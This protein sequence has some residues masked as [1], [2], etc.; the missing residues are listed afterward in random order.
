MVDRRILSAAL[1]WEASDIEESYEQRKYSY[2][3][4]LLC[5]LDTSKYNKIFKYEK[6]KTKLGYDVYLKYEKKDDYIT[7]SFLTDHMIQTDK[8]VCEFGNIDSTCADFVYLIK[9]SKNINDNYYN[10]RFQIELIRERSGRILD[11]F[12]YYLLPAAK[13]K[14]F[15]IEREGDF[16]PLDGIGNFKDNPEYIN[17]GFDYFSPTKNEILYDITDENNKKNCIE[18]YNGN[19]IGY[20]N[21]KI[22]NIINKISSLLLSG[23]GETDEN[24]YEGLVYFVN[25]LFRY[26]KNT[27]FDYKHYKFR[28]SP[29]IKKWLPQYQIYHYAAVVQYKNKKTGETGEVNFG[30]HYYDGTLFTSPD[31]YIQNQVINIFLNIK[32]KLFQYFVFNE[33]INGFVSNPNLLASNE[34]AKFVDVLYEYKFPET[35][36]DDISVILDD[37]SE[38]MEKKLYL[39]I[40]LASLP[41][42]DIY[43]MYSS[44]LYDIIPYFLKKLMNDSIHLNSL[45]QLINPFHC[46]EIPNYT[47]YKLHQYMTDHHI[48][49]ECAIKILYM[50]KIIHKK[51]ASNMLL[52]QIIYLA[53]SFKLERHNDG[54]GSYITYNFYKKHEVLL[55]STL[56]SKLEHEKIEVKYIAPHY[57]F[58]ICKFYIKGYRLYK[59]DYIYNGKFYHLEAS[60]YDINLIITLN[61]IINRMIKNPKDQSKF[62]KVIHIINHL[63]GGRSSWVYKTYAEPMKA[64][65]FFMLN[66]DRLDD[67]LLDRYFSLI[68]KLAVPYP[69]VCGVH[70]GNTIK[71]IVISHMMPL[72]WQKKLTD[73]HFDDLENIAKPFGD[74]NYNKNEYEIVKNKLNAYLA[75]I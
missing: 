3:R 9:Y 10:K 11:E 67:H 64:F 18:L 52:S 4:D 13:K 20:E 37:T 59:S 60:K 22:K 14:F 68:N 69:S 41:Y 25:F 23:I 72:L 61:L 24:I 75:G 7:I 15:K 29:D 58:D 34:F 17:G 73:A 56:I 53:G 30:Y 45:E 43:Y 57:I 47:G 63:V 70:F 31:E 66:T 55:L 32:D 28:K 36:I 21:S 74:G 54:R 26:K 62:T 12:Y 8:Q 35:Y 16:D 50:Y 49:I 2:V 46:I 6:E 48:T 38:K 42:N 65:A 44:D 39:Y 71:N 40:T 33:F 19:L 5:V 1:V 27:W 51:H